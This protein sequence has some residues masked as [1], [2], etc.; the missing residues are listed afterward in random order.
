MMSFTG[1]AAGV[2]GQPL[3][4]LERDADVS[5]LE[6]LVESTADGNGQLVVIEGRAGVGKTSLVAEARRIAAD[7]GRRVLSARCGELEQEFAFGVVRQL[8]EPMIAT[9]SADQRSELFAGAADLASPLF[10]PAALAAPPPA[11]DVSFAILHGLYWLAANAALA[12]PTAILVDD[13][14]WCDA[15]SLRWLLHVARRLEGLP[16]LVTVGTRPPQPTAPGALL[17]ELI[18]DPGATRLEPSMLGSESVASLARDLLA[19]DPDAPFCAACRE[20]TGGNPLYLRALLTTLAADGLAPTGENAERVHEVGPEPVARI[21]ALRLSRLSADAEALARA[22]AVLGH[23]A[24]I[25]LAA[26]LAGVDRPRA[27]AAVADLVRAEILRSEPRLEFT[28]PIVRTSI[29]ERLEPDER[30]GAHRHAAELLVASGAEPEQAA[31]HLLLVP[32]E[33]G[34]TVTPVLTDAARRALVRGSATT[35]VAYLRRA[36][37]EPGDAQLRG[38]LL[39]SLGLAERGVDQAAAAEHLR[40]A[41]ELTADAEVATEL[42]LECGRALYFGLR[43]RDARD[44]FMRA[45]SRLGARRRDLRELLETETM[46]VSWFEPEL[47]PA[48]QELLARVAAQSL[49]GGIESNLRLAALAHYETRR[50]TDRRLAISLAERALHSRVIEQGS[51]FGLYYAVIA[52]AIAGQTAAAVTVCDRAM[53]DARRRGDLLTTLS[54]LTWRGFCAL[55]RGE[56]RDA[57]SDLR[58]GLELGDR[59]GFPPASI[60]TAPFLAEV[61]VERGDFDEA[62]SLLRGRGFGERLPE[63]LHFTFFRAARGRVATAQRQPARALDEYETDGRIAATLDLANPAYTPWRGGAATALLGLGRTSDA[64]SVAAEELE[65]AV[66][67]GTPRCVGI[68]L[69]IL[70]QAE[71]GPERQRR[72]REAVDVLEG[73]DARLEHARALVE[74]GAELRRGNERS[75]ARRVLRHGVELAH[76]CGATALAER[77]N[78]ELAATGARPRKMLQTGPE[79]LTASERRV[80]QLAAEELSNKEIAQALFVTVKT[81]E[82]HLSSVYRKLD[83]SSRRQLAVALADPNALA[84][85]VG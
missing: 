50:G 51:S 32:S 72:L 65:L 3:R 82:V 71:T 47:Y 23:S 13:L 35:A 46:H 76:R 48:A 75:A 12:Q 85:A 57:E 24:D 28:H 55:Q 14:H 69:R 44:V 8:F 9:A 21:V 67:W 26:T 25:G 70:G 30:A 53:T 56:L 62:D 61:L 17:T 27:S 81:I 19:G 33:A 38:R 66:R 78:E 68:A 59:T 84:P 54:T 34:T 11:G 49:G 64:R 20:A 10:D 41:I 1:A 5:A 63:S 73:A 39:A 37:A 58:E 6:A 31:A 16:L 79:S 7:A 74:L 40:E 15:P 36:L 77:G 4:L 60:Y 45:T 80:A 29:Y 18:S 52:L 42:A 22:V 83:V 2:G 43:N